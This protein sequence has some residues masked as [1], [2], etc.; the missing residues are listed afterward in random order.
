VSD[1]MADLIERLERAR[2]GLGELTQRSGNSAEVLRL[3]GK[4]GGTVPL[5]FAGVGK[6]QR[7]ALMSKDL[8]AIACA[9]VIFLVFVGYN[10]A[11]ALIASF[12]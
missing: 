10:I 7:Y 2:H 6:C 4:A 3:S 11:D 8:W 9:C 5:G 12:P 1:D